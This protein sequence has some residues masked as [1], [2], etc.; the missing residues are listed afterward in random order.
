MP[1]P[2]PVLLRSRRPADPTA[3]WWAY[4]LPLALMLASDYKL[5]SRDVDQAVGGS[6]DL[7]V[8]LEIAVYGAAALYLVRRFGLRPPR[9]KITG[10]LTAA[11][12]WAGYAALSAL[13]SPFKALGLVRG[14]QLLVTMLVAHAV[15]TRATPADLRR[16]AHAFVAIVLA[17]VAV[18]VAH[19][20]PRTKHTEARFN[21]LYVHPV[22]GGVYLGIAVL[23]VIGYLIRWTAPAQRQWRV[24]VYLGALAVLAGALLATQTR[25][26]AL[27]AVVGV[28]VLLCTARGPKGRVDVAVV[29]AAVGTLGALAFAGTI[30][31][32]VARGEDA[33]KLASLNSRT[34]LWSLALKAYAE[35]PVYGRGLGASRGLFLADIGLGGGHN[36]FINA[37]VDQGAL[38]VAAFGVLLLTLSIVLLFLV[39]HRTL[40]ADAGMLLGILAFFV[41][42]GI[43]TEGLAAP[44]NVSGIWLFLLVAWTETL[45]R[46]GGD[47]LPADA[48][49]TTGDA[50]AE[51]PPS[52]ALPPPAQVGDQPQHA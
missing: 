33:Q 44:A 13:W 6:A 43:T 2:R 23:L 51:P 39:R 15:A 50:G 41:T 52:A 40:R 10:L 9:R 48:V 31:A 1:L 26:A 7:T 20:F 38:G 49:T 8:L 12:V 21:W 37:L 16:L 22:I 36:A 42:D 35:S 24:P 45:R 28:L 14:T 46:Q 30:V 19:P 4:V 34:E 32:F 5:R 25:G 3:G 47:P 29:G 18:G 17:S 11:W 27:G